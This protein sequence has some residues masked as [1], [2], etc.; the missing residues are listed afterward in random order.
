MK[1]KTGQWHT[2]L[3]ACGA[4]VPRRAGARASLDGGQAAADR[5]AIPR[6]AGMPMLME[7]GRAHV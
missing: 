7:I 1:R 2:S 6:P 5:G 3:D 4:T